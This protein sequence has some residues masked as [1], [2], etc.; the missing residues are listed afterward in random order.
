MDNTPPSRMN[1][2]EDLNYTGGIMNPAKNIHF[3]N[4]TA[5]RGLEIS[6]KDYRVTAE[7]Y[8]DENTLPFIAMSFE[9]DIRITTYEP[10]LIVGT[11]PNGDC[12]VI[13]RKTPK[14]RSR[15]KLEINFPLP[16]EA[17]LFR[18]RY[19]LSNARACP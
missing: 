12:F 6:G 17:R 10:D 7:G 11:I 2:A 4:G 16:H 18:A 9:G 15:S 8:L 1:L 3:T 13:E 5:G 14:G 19:K